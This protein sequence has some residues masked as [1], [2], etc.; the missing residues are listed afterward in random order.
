MKLKTCVNN[1]LQVN[2]AQECIQ[3]CKGRVCFTDCVNNYWPGATFNDI[4]DNEGITINYEAFIELY[5]LHTKFRQLSYIHI[6]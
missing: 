5:N 2:D 1:T 4:I 6:Y 3:G